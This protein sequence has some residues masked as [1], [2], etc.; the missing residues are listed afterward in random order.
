M[1][2]FTIAAHKILDTIPQK[3]IDYVRKVL[4]D[5]S[6]HYEY[7]IAYRFLY[8][9]EYTIDEFAQLLAQTSEFYRQSDCPQNIDCSYTWTEHSSSEE[10]PILIEEVFDEYGYLKSNCFSKNSST[11]IL[12]GIEKHLFKTYFVTQDFNDVRNWVKSYK[13]YFVDFQPNIADYD[14][15][16]AAVNALPTQGYVYRVGSGKYSDIYDMY[17]HFKM[18]EPNWRK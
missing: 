14:A 15:F 8:G 17:A 7:E 13:D 4:E 18:E 6:Q 3:A 10:K 5:Q 1:R 12:C 2:T 9:G 16:V 11:T